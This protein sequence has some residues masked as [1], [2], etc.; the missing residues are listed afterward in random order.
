MKTFCALLAVS[1]LGG[2]IALADPYW[3]S[4]EGDDLPET[5]GWERTVYAGGDQRSIQDGTL[6]L[7]GR[8]SIDIAD[9]YRMPISDP[10]P[11]ELFVAEWRVWV[12]D[13]PGY[14]DP[15][16][17][18]TSSGHGAL[19]LAYQED[20]IY[21]LLEG[22]Y[23]YFTPDIFH[24]YLLTSSDMLSYD[25]YIDGTFTYAGVFVGP[26]PQSWTAWGDTTQG[27]SSLSY[28][29]YVRFGVVPEPSAGL[30]LGSAALAM[31]GLRGRERL[32]LLFPIGAH[33]PTQS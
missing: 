18:V 17:A 16:I 4:Y 30:L 28:W 1:A 8:A 20:R 27:A 12:G 9:F 23:I 29:D 15:G 3:I 10:D 24:D 31:T 13:I 25:L 7:D 14:P 6:V 21:S 26:F 11:G 22:V 19:V 5:E 33:G 2:S 32:E